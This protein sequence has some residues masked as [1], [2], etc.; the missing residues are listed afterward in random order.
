MPIERFESVP[1]F[2]RTAVSR[3]VEKHHYFD[4]AEWGDGLKGPE[5]IRRA[6]NGDNSFAKACENTITHLAPVF[7][8]APQ[9][10]YQPDF[11]GSRVNVGAYLSGDPMC[12]RRKT[13]TNQ[14]T[15]HITMYVEVDSS[16][17]VN[18]ETM[19]KRGG[20]ILALLEWLQSANVGVDLYLI[21]CCYGTENEGFYGLIRV[22][23]RPLDLANSAF[24]IAHPAFARRLCYAY[25][26][27]TSY[28]G[29][30]W[31]RNST[32]W[33]I[34]SARYA[35]Y[36]RSLLQM[37]PGDIY[38]PAASYNDPLVRTPETW[39]KDRIMQLGSDGV[40]G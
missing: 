13:R 15:P 14:A 34:T 11:A 6:L 31:P 8:S 25:S 19:L 2:V 27:V 9:F 21:T 5:V 36:M 4:T 22:E 1:E 7:K 40:A 12:M 17:G 28:F 39:L 18:Q 3:G 20:A 32:A 23:S 37:S 26:A 10:S 29:N 35:E 30:G 33:G 38:V 16:S 24:A